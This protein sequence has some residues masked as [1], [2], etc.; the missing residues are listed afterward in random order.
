VTSALDT[1]PGTGFRWV[2][3]NLHWA[4]SLFLVAG[5]VP[6]FRLV[7]LPLR[8]TWSSYFLTYWW[9]LA[10]QSIGLAIVLYVIGFPSEFKS[11][12]MGRTG[13]PMHPREQVLGILIPAAYLFLAFIVI[14]SYNDVIAYLRFDG[15][16]DVVLN[17]IDS[18]IMGGLTAASLQRLVPMRVLK[19][20]EV[21]YIGMFPQI[22]A[23][24][25]FLSLRCGRK[26]AMKFIG[27]IV[28]SYYLGLFIFFLVPATGPYYLSAMNHDGSYLGDG[29][30][31]FV[32]MLKVLSSH[33]PLP[34]VGTDYF[35]ALPCLHLTQP[36]IVLWFVRRWKRI[37]LVLAAYDLL[38]VPSIVLLQQHYVV[39]LIGGVAVAVLAIVM[40]EGLPH[41]LH[42]QMVEESECP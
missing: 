39:D 7:H 4:V 3:R 5:L 31:E 23:C 33:H 26:E 27:A 35:V 15:S 38:L 40:M 6:A 30:I 10:V 17:R 37:A 36:I 29:E 22:G 20:M 25:I 2:S 1:P 11:A 21:V 19:G 8:F 14:F 32:R 18:R 16:A 13:P 12:I 41:S 28:T 34:I 9:A 24:L 42:A